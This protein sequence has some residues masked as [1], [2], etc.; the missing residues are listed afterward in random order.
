M[1]EAAVP[2]LH[3]AWLEGLIAKAEA[4]KDAL[5]KA[6]SEPEFTKIFWGVSGDS[7]DLCRQALTIDW[8]RAELEG[9]AG[10]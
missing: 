8:L 1:L 5:L 9:G 2:I 7:L 3:R 4:K 10:E 6:H